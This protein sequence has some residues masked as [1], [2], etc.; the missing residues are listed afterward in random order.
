MA[1]TED[2]TEA[3]VR[4]LILLQ[5]LGNGLGQ[6]ARVRLALLI[7][8]I[9][10]VLQRIDPA[11]PGRE[12]Y[13][14]GR[15]Q[16]VLERSRTLTRETFDAW[17]RDLRQELAE[18]GVQQAGVAR[19]ILLASLGDTAIRVR[20]DGIGVNYFKQVL[21]SRPFQGDTLRGWAERQE[22]ATIRRLRTQLQIGVVNNETVDQLVRRVRGRHTGRYDT[23]TLA[24]GRRRRLGRFRGG[25]LGATTREAEA[26]VRTA[27]NEIA[28]RAHM[29]TY[30]QNQDIT[31]TYE[32]VATLDSRTTPICQALDGRVF[33]YDDPSRKEPPQHYNCR[34]GV[35]PI[36]DWQGLGLD[37]PQDG[38]RSAEGGPV[39]ATT[40]YEEWLRRQTP[41]KRREI[42]GVGKA[43][44][45][46]AGEVS[47]RDLVRQ[48]GTPVRLRDLE[49]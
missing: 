9:I 38:T 37:A 16:K 23:V 47:L 18:I 13:R 44:L 39:S 10:N 5:Q 35:R 33:R 42:L 43:R 11:A 21:D 17:Y 6:D 12:V 3:A 41:A 36:I 28:N 40:N 49:R 7:D 48:D 19:D 8:E 4:N 30:E 20:L 45:F 1:R 14:L 2:P 34:S 46:D 29:A 32:Y 31:Q 25:V 27:V 15:V 24:S 22:A 26:I